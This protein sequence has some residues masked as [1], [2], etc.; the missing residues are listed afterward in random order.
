MG[1]WISGT[2]RNLSFWRWDFNWSGSPNHSKSGRFGL[3]FKWFF[4]KGWP[5]VQISNGRDSVFQI[6]FETWIV[7]NPTSFWPFEIQTSLDFRSPLYYNYIQNLLTFKYLWMLPKCQKFYKISIYFLIC[8]LNFLFRFEVLSWFLRQRKI[9]WVI[10]ILD[11]RFRLDRIDSW[12]DDSWL[13]SLTFME[14]VI[15][16]GAGIAI[17]ALWKKEK[18]IVDTVNTG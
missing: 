10:F 14:G 2:I 9:C 8:Q 5:F 4:T 13:L 16:V 1:I 7:G 17:W 15:W 12:F 6:P 18:I 11:F 3:D